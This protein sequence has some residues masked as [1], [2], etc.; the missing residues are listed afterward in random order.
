MFDRMKSVVS[1]NDI[2]NSPNREVFQRL[3]SSNALIGFLKNVSHEHRFF[4]HFTTASALSSIFKTMKWKFS[5]ARKTNDLHEFASKGSFDE[6]KYIFSCSLS[7]GDEDNIG[8]W[9]MYGDRKDSI[10]LKIKK[11]AI[12]NWIHDI[13]SNKNNC[14]TFNTKKFEEHGLE[15]EN[16]SMHDI[17]YIHGWQ[18]PQQ[19]LLS[20]GNITNSVDWT[21]NISSEACLTGFIKNSAWE[22]EKETRIMIRLSPYSHYNQ[23]FEIPGEVYLKVSDTLIRGIEEISISPFAT[24][25]KDKIYG[26]IQTVLKGLDNKTLH[27]ICVSESYFCGKIKS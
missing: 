10:C 25:S 3:S 27:H 18:I 16:V 24:E 15:I 2:Y 8:M 22:Y 1:C 19:S 14:C 9:K 12:L 5:S 4:Y 23:I 21:E 20:W 7:H 11:E 13:E 6:W 17:A 26:N